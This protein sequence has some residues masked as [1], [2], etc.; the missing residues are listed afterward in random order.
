MNSV[1]SSLFRTF[2]AQTK[3]E[4]DMRPPIYDANDVM[5]FA[6][7]QERTNE[8]AEEL[9]EAFLEIQ[10]NHMLSKREVL[11]TLARVVDSFIRMEE[12]YEF[13]ESKRIDA[14][15]VFNDYYM[16]CRDLEDGNE[17][18]GFVPSQGGN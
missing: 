4:S 18:D 17:A 8:A 16:A 1:F 15:A 3:K 10:Q 5:E 13:D 12:D 14:E 11:F 2:V 6:E 7:M 9:E